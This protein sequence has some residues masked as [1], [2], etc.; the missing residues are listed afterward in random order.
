MCFTYQLALAPFRQEWLPNAKKRDTVSQITKNELFYG[1]NI[2]SCTFYPSSNMIMVTPNKKLVYKT[3]VLQW[4]IVICRKMLCFIW[5]TSWGS[6]IICFTIR[7]KWT[8][9]NK[10]QIQRAPCLLRGLNSPY[11]SCVRC[12]SNS[13]SVRAGF[14][15]YFI[16]MA[17]PTNN[18]YEQHSRSEF[19]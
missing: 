18:H 8:T 12:K 2:R 1:D 9:E 16:R 14:E 5:I 11:S 7:R 17:A 15:I 10:T 4:C 19:H 3:D 6:N 13:V